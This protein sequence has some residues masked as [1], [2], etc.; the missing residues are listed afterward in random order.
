MPDAWETSHGL[1]TNIASN[2]GDYDAD[3]YTNL[4]EYL[5]DLA[6]FKAIGPLEFDGS[7]RYADSSNWTRNWEPS[8]VDDV[9]IDTGTAT[10]DAI[11]QRAGTLGVGVT[12][13]SNGML[14]VASG[15]IEITN[16]LAVGASGAG[17]V[18]HSGGDVTVL[19]G[20]VTVN[21]TY[22][23]SGGALNTPLL[24]RGA[25]GQFNL[26]G[27][28]LNA[29]VVD[30]D[31]INNGG[32]IA[33]GDSP[34][35]THITGDLTLSS[36]VL[37]IEIGGTAPGQYDQLGVDGLTTLG[38]T[39]KVELVDVGGGTYV[40]QLGD[41]FGFLAAFGGGGGE[42][43]DFDLP[44]LAPGLAWGI[45]PGDVTIFLSVV[46]APGNPGDFNGDGFVDGT[47]LAAWRGGF[48]STDQPNNDAGDAD[49]DGDVDGGDFLIW[50][51][52]LGA[53][54][55]A[56]SIPEPSSSALGLLA[57]VVLCG[58]YRSVRFEVRANA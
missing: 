57:S 53:G 44:E 6:A 35:M 23:M 1:P 27:G 48:G 5:N 9:L 3:G 45:S 52:E 8:R 18:N 14:N 34:G 24:S 28:R 39:L 13:G 38:G 17:V 41:S 21:G 55:G 29:D 15:W 58:Y 56:S 4:E 31:L 22:N 47:D 2:N 10:I 26:T 37:E 54:S 46:S 42:F 36:G 7:G 20:E 33:P 50:Q 51:R 49:G 16:D 25:Q 12:P 19:N 30:L 32:V 11:G 40:P 43:D